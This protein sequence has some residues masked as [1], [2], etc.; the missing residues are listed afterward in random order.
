MKQVLANLDF[1]DNALNNICIEKIYIA[2]VS[3]VKSK[4]HTVQSLNNL[5]LNAWRLESSGVTTDKYI[6]LRR[7]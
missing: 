2:K 5:L 3:G 4:K 7:W 1:T 6:K